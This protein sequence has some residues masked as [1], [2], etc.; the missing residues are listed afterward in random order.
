MPR[1]EYNTVNIT[2]DRQ[3]SGNEFGNFST[4][5]Y[6]ITSENSIN[7]DET[8]VTNNSELNDISQTSTRDHDDIDKK[9]SQRDRDLIE[10]AANGIECLRTDRR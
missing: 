8:N 7:R 3:V 5:E 2:N 10:D 4:N 9:L 6:K 1:D